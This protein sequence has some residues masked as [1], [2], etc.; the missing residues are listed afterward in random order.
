MWM[1]RQKNPQFVTNHC[2]GNVSPR[3]SG[4][5]NQLCNDKL[6]LAQLSAGFNM[7]RNSTIWINTLKFRRPW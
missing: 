5:F 1:V 7:I 3:V 2:F 6:I 4:C